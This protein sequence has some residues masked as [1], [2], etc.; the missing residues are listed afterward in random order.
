[1]TQPCIKRID[2][3][4]PDKE[5]MAEAANILDNGGIVVAPTETRYGLLGIADKQAV[6]EKIYSIKG[7]SINMPTA[8]FIRSL[9][10]INDYGEETV[11]SRILA[12]KYLPGPLTLVLRAKTDLKPPI[13]INGKIGLRYS[14]SPV[15]QAIMEKVS[16]PLCATSA[17]LSGCDEADSIDM[18][19]DQISD[20][21][22]LFLDAGPLRTPNSTVV[23]CSG[24]RAVIL[25]QGG[26][27]ESEIEK[28][29]RSKDVN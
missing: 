7:H 18:I 11:I 2:P 23:D 3:I 20:G 15:M 1:M 10:C 16:F 14:S 28:T 29:L 21:V 19:C 26:I 27:S 4:N 24:D 22:D 13:A 12:G 5:I 17:N 6:A 8:I 9:E 25:R